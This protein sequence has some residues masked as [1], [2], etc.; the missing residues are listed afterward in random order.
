MNSSI[1]QQAVKCGLRTVVN[2]QALL[3]WIT[4]LTI[5]TFVVL[6]PLK[7]HSG[8][9]ERGLRLA[10]TGKAFIQMNTPELS[11]TQN[12]HIMIKSLFTFL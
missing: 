10:W 1:Q 11:I 7:E 12:E 9:S 8:L 3:C 5:I 6:L 2:L 4:S